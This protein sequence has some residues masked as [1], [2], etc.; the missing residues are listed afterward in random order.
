MKEDSSKKRKPKNRKKGYHYEGSHSQRETRKMINDLTQKGRLYNI[1]KNAKTPISRYEARM[2]YTKK[3]GRG[4][5]DG[6]ASGRIAELQN[7]NYV[8]ASHSG[9]TLEPG[10]KSIVDFYVAK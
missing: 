4:I 7:D 3:Y 5:K 8:E 10:V 1:I 2:I 6:T 9:R